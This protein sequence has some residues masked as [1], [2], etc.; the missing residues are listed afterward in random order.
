[1]RSPQL[2]VY[3]NPNAPSADADAPPTLGRQLEPLARQ[4]GWLFRESRQRAACLALLSQQRCTVL[5]LRLER[6]LVD[7]MSLLAEA[8][9]L[10]PD[11]PCLVVNEV[12]LDAE[13]RSALSAMAYDLGARHVL[14]P[15]VAAGTVERVLARLMQA[16]A[17]RT[18]PAPEVPSAPA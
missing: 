12:R 9:A 4:N 18:A 15:P 11:A 14:T 10:A 7:E 8:S 5:V 13:Q 2:V 3:E 16:T 1:M 17:A 6:K